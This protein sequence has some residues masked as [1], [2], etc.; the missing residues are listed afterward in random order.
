MHG[1]LSLALCISTLTLLSLLSNAQTLNQSYLQELKDDARGPYAAI[2][3]FCEDGT[4]REAKDPCPEPMKGW[5][6]AIYK[7]RVEQIAQRDHIFLD[8]ILTGTEKEDFWDDRHQNSR[9]KQYQ[10]TNYLFNADNGW[11]LEKAQNYRGAKQ[12]EDEKEW[13]Q[14]FLEWL[15]TSN[16]RTRDNYL[17]VKMA[18]IDIPHG[19]DTNVAQRVRAYSK[20]LAEEKS[21]FMNTRI[22]LHNNPTASDTSLVKAWRDKNKDISGKALEYYDDLVTDLKELYK[23]FVITDLEQYTKHLTPGPFTDAIRAKVK[24]L[25]G[26]S[27]ALR[28]MEASETLRFLR[29]NFLRETRPSVRVDLIDL[30]NELESIAMQDMDA[31]KEESLGDIREKMC[32]LTE[33][34]YGAGYIETWEYDKIKND[35]SWMQDSIVSLEGLDYYKYATQKIVLWSSQMVQ[36]LYAE[37]VQEFAQ[38]EPLTYGFVDDKIRSSLILP[39]GKLVEIIN[40]FYG[41]VAYNASS[42][43][44]NKND[45]GTQG[46]NPGLARGKLYVLSTIPESMAIDKTGI[47]AFDRPPAEMKP[48]AG[49]L[50]VKEGNPV[51]H[52]QLLA[53]N[54]G[55]PNG[56]ISSNVLNQL[57]SYDGEEV[58]YAVSPG[59]TMMLKLA[60]D[61]TAEENKLFDT[62]K[63]TNNRITIS[64][65]KVVLHPDSLLDMAKINASFSGVWCGPK[66]ANLGQLKQMFPDHVVNGIVIPFGVF[67]DHME[68]K[69]P[70]QDY[71]Y[72]T[73]LKNIFLV[74]QEKIK[75]GVDRNEVEKETLNALALLRAMIEE[76]PLKSSLVSNLENRFNSILGQRMGNIPVF[77]RSDTNMEDLPQ[78]SGAGLNLTLFNVVDKQKIIDGIKKVW[79]SPY[80]ERSYQWRQQFLNNPEDVY[81][82]IL[83]IPSVNVDKSGVIITKGISRGGEGDINISFSRGVGGAVEGQSAESYVIYRKGYSELISPGRETKYRNIP[84]SG[85]SSY[86]YI[87]LTDPV[88]DPSDLKQLKTMAIS[89]A[90]KMDEV[91]GTQHTYDIELG[92][93]DGFIWL[94]QVRPFVENK[95]ALG[96]DYLKKLDPELK[97]IGILM[98]PKNQ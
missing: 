90:Q 3:W 81:P 11:I 52:V 80:T 49:I 42:I 82:S 92:I 19:E 65:D 58:F 51:S 61:M 59:G 33:G 40:K 29:D 54:L 35:F 83:I 25:D 98:E 84:P 22:K 56:L 88:L 44:G 66:A 12:V 7:S 62:N 26:A 79:A 87:S 77:L 50:N 34:I 36:S 18:A 38:F 94:F 95:D 39:T 89:I 2:K 73:F 41:Q 14:K 28:A 78:F 70:N 64:M 37:P 76:M 17:L 6:H 24:N 47:Y 32:F 63:K 30:A 9:L 67:R 69:V 31:I 71:T 53:R 45:A 68:Q 46:L 21:N 5:Q 48:V 43:M 86:K 10:I 1:G 23:P 75:N 57:K 96:S 16:E 55:I 13:G 27:A 93:K 4:R 8:Q 91:T 74:E 85:G 97:N 20:L 72:W 15:V 60:S